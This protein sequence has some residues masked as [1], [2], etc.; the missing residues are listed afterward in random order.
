MAVEDT[1]TT[2]HYLTL[3]PPCENHKISVISLP[4][5]MPNGERITSTHTEL[6]SKT[7]PPIEAWEAHLFTGIN[8]ALQSIE[9]FCDHGYQAVFDDKKVLIL[10]KSNGK[11]IMKG[12]QDPLSNLYM[13]NLTQRG[14]LMTEFRTL[15]DFFSKN[16]YQCKSKDTLVDYHH[17]TCR[18]STQSWWVKENLKTSL[19]GRAYHLT[20]C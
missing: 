9:T 15:S 3:D 8:K 13:L 10:N 14:N 18:R 20:W 1:W 7:D 17:A 12:R 4:I 6:I 19:I 11:I 5:H 2:G 16:V